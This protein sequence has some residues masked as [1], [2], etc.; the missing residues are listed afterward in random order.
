MKRILILM[1]LI[2]GMTQAVRAQK[3]EAT[4]ASLPESSK[5]L[6]VTQDRAS[7]FRTER[8]VG[9]R[10]DLDHQVLRAA[11]RIESDL[12]P[13]ATAELTARAWLNAEGSPFGIRSS[14]TLELI[15][16]VNS[17]GAQ[18]LTFRQTLAGVPVY[19]RFVQI[20]LGPQGQPTMVQSGYAP[21]LEEIASFNP[22]PVISR[23]QAE[24]IAGEAIAL[25]GD[26]H[27]DSVALRVYPDAVPRLVWR[28]LAWPNGQPGDWEVLL[29]AHSGEII[30]L[31]DRRMYR[32][33]HSPT[34]S[35]SHRRTDGRGLVWIPDPI[36][37]AG[38]PYG[39]S[40]QD[41][42]DADREVL[43][44]ERVEVDL[45]DI[46][47]RSDGR[48]WLEGPYVRIDGSFDTPWTP[49]SESAPDAFKYTRADDRFEAVMVYYHIDHNQRYIQSLDVGRSIQGQG[50]RANPHGAGAMDNSWYSPGRNAV[51]FGDGGIDDAEDAE[52][53]IHEYGHAVLH[54]GTANAIFDSREGTAVHEGWSDYWAVSYTRSLMDRGV[55]P[56][57][58]WR[59]VFS[60]VGNITW[61]GRFLNADNVRYPD[62]FECPRLNFCDYYQDGVY[63]A[64]TLM[65]IWEELG[66]ETTD[67]L[68]FLSHPY[69]SFPTTLGDAAEAL[70]QADRDHYNG[71]HQGV[72]NRWLGLRGFVEGPKL[73]LDHTPAPIHRDVN[74]PYKVKVT[75]VPKVTEATVEYRK[76]GQAFQSLALDKGRNNTWTGH[77]PLDAS[78]IRLEY[79]L[80]GRN[81]PL[82]ATLPEDA[83]NTLFQVAV[84]ED[85][86]APTV[87]HLPLTHITPEQWPAELA[88]DANDNSGIKTVNIKFKLFN[89]S[90]Q[91]RAART[92][93]LVHAADDRY[94]GTLATEQVEVG[95]YV[96]YRVH[97]RDLFNNKSVFPP[98]EEDPLRLDV[99]APGVLAAWTPQRHSPELTGTWVSGD[100]ADFEV[101]IPGD[102]SGW[103]T[104]PHGTYS[105]QP[106]VS[107]LLFPPVNLVN[108]PEAHL[109]F[110]H[111][112][113]LEHI[114][115]PAPGA[116][117]GTVLDGGN[118]K[119]STDDGSTWTL[120]EPEAGYNG[121]IADTGG[122][123]MAGEPAFGGF[124]YGWHRVLVPLP[125]APDGSYRF[126]VRPRLDFGT[127]TG[128]TESSAHQYAGW[129]ITGVRVVADRPE[130]TTAPTLRRAPPLMTIIPNEGPTPPVAVSTEDDVGIESVMVRYKWIPPDETPRTD[131]FR[132]VQDPADLTRFSGTF[133]FL[134]SLSVG[135]RIEYQLEI[136][137]FDHNETTA[138]AAPSARF[139]MEG[140]R[141][142]EESALA[143]AALTGYWTRT[144]N[145]LET[146]A[147]GR[148]DV[149]SVVFK[150]FDTPTNV[151]RVIL[152]LH[153]RYHLRE[154]AHAALMQ[155]RDGGASWHA[156]DPGQGLDLTGTADSLAVTWYD[157]TD[158]GGTQLWL[159]LDLRT[160]R[161][162]TKE[163]YWN[164]SKAQLISSTIEPALNAHREIALNPN[165]PDP[166]N[167]R[168]TISYTIPESMPVELEVYT[169]LGRRIRTVVDQVQLA[170]TYQL[171]IDLKGFAS[172]LYLLRMVAGE[173]RFTESMVL[174]RQ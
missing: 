131:V 130:D 48:Y 126:N 98:T 170:G 151:S 15:K 3:G 158:L 37:S 167:G 118:I 68:N 60:W 94:T 163:E 103:A 47:R 88:V 23:T 31:M 113:D 166:F 27:I 52:I 87:V 64:A 101:H 147:E 124:S 54:A 109:E 6:V 73:V 132:L 137:D 161:G 159:R 112:H 44:R 105:P 160:P 26:A 45:L 119:I 55:V 17:L 135:E 156:V 92:V 143:D 65:S 41:F 38:V 30:H 114:G 4:F 71:A 77:I 2:P 43:N 81:G 110:W 145:G 75:I 150:P 136:R 90:G 36:T 86:T 49:N 122:N 79:Y 128:N 121:P 148:Y 111:W 162:L 59:K 106:G 12:P 57:T 28:V 165:F 40:Y 95:Y 84:G 142:Q 146:T 32:H 102:H 18:H 20:N 5:A 16:E 42:G 152:S 174:T 115:V 1:V 97:V 85:M 129:I 39:G 100:T 14:A 120:V 9:G 22:V 169:L 19:R 67:R 62:D 140:H 76:N 10:I 70:L 80:R 34:D 74:V 56:R 50:V 96:T 78:T 25:A 53:I 21:H 155:S 138:P 149:S 153:H 104:N 139:V 11:Y 154:S 51:S 144:E 107:T 123:P 82:E 29:D 7:Q 168:T 116:T 8:V 58:D 61:D 173:Q 164:L 46:T 141:Q 72:L 63:F 117:T 134:Q 89:A 66:K 171:D 33:S 157:F 91:R 24:N 108:F 83:P 125:E 172:G 93:G 69:L 133:P 99:I 35:L 13:Q 127:D